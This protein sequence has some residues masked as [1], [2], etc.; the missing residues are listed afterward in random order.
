MEISEIQLYNTL[1][2]KLGD[3]ETQ[4]LIDALKT[5]IKNEFMELKQI[6]LV[7]DDK[8]DILGAIKED[9][10]ELMKMMK[11]DKIELMK[12]MKE[13]KIELMKTMQEDKIELMKTMKE[14]KIELTKTMKMDRTE[15]LVMM[16]KDKTDLIR[17]IYLASVI[18]FIAIVGALLGILSFILKH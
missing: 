5:F 12:M 14:D 4:E 18:N 8:I 6:L 7:K 13:D 17:G 9:K 1:R 3:Q 11:E 16:K 10:I 2:P 15:L